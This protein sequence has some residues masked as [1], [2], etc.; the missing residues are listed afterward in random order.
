MSDLQPLPPGSAA[1]VPLQN[2]VQHSEP[3]VQA[4][5]AWRQAVPEH[6][7]ATQESEQHSP[8]VW[9]GPPCGLQNAGVVQVAEPDGPEHIPEQHSEADWHDALAPLQASAGDRQ[10][11]A[12][13]EVSQRPEQQSLEA[14]Q[15]WSSCLQRF[16]GSVQMPFA[17]VLVQQSAPVVHAAPAALQVAVA[18]QT[19]PAQPRPV[20]QSDGVVQASLACLQAGTWQVRAAP[21]V[22]HSRPMQQSALVRHGALATPQVGGGKQVPPVHES[23]P[24][25]QGT[26]DEQAP[27]VA[28]QVAGATHIVPVP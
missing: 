16:E 14:V 10:T 24:R 5:P 28:P 18:T 6:A 22:G 25:Q 11:P 3:E 7:P 15:P 21:A 17:Q 9:Q 23:V 12:P 26:V 2:P 4:T 27:F 8:E 1:Q 13:P 20:Q 19:F